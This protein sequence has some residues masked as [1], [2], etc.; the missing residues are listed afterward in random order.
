MH[1][2][3]NS[4]VRVDFSL[5]VG[6]VTETVSVSAS[7]AILQ[8]DRADLGTKIETQTLEN[9]PLTFNR[10]YQGV[11][12]LV[13]GASRPFRPHSSF[14]NSQDSLSTYVNGQ[15]RQ[16]S[17]FMIEGIN[18]DWDNGNL[19]VVVPSVEAIQTVDVTT[20]N[21]DAEFG[22]VTG[23][24]TNVILKSGTN[25]WHGSAFEFNKVAALAA[26]NYFAVKTPPLVYNLFGGTFGGRIRR[27]KTFFFADYQG[28][29]DRESAAIGTLTIP[30]VAFRTG[31][32]SSGST[33]IYDPATGNADG[34]GR[35][36]FPGNIIP[37]SRISPI[38]TKILA[39]VPAPANPLL[40]GNYPY[41]VPQAKN[42][43]NFDVKV[44]HQFTSN[45]SLNVRYSY[46]TPEVAV[47][48]V[49]G[50]AGGPGT[51]VLRAQAPREVRRQV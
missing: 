44:D 14:Y 47:P 22:R 2:D 5:Q 50:I 6:S 51:A 1:L 13:P 32:L 20:S 46:Q 35:S 16:A 33:R 19:T 21:Y 41:A 18:N 27:D 24:V 31:D 49:F 4:T 30:P 45:N 8:T 25:D 7:A 40:S 38:A 28:L 43:N 34:T 11:I 15:F 10:N 26:K 37:A 29:R 12:G 3:A 9:L 23:A 36:L 39:F 17:S 42:T 48:P